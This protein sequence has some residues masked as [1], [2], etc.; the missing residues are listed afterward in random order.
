MKSESMGAQRDRSPSFSS[1]RQLPS[2]A[3]KSQLP[4]ITSTRSTLRMT[5]RS[6]IIA[7]PSSMLS[8]RQEREENSEEEDSD[9]MLSIGHADANHALPPSAMLLQ[10][11]DDDDSDVGDSASSAHLS[12]VLSDGDEATDIRSCNS[13]QML[14]TIDIKEADKI[15]SDVTNGEDGE[16]RLQN[17]DALSVASN[18]DSLG[19]PTRPTVAESEQDKRVAK[20][21]ELEKLLRERMAKKKRP[22]QKL[23]SMDDL[24]DVPSHSP[25][26][27]SRFIPDSTHLVPSEAESK[28][29]E[30]LNDRLKKRGSHLEES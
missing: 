9:E 27:E 30:R 7:P 8:R 6:G 18:D 19:G 21:L 13:Q 3:V 24:Q 23:K 14:T 10:Q 15:D 17:A 2:L 29:R 28:L 22:P 11:V 20:R 25:D 5:T 1:P 12:A 16:G 26:N 4:S